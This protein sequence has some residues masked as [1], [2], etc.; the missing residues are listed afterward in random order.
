MQISDEILNKINIAYENVHK[1]K[2]L[3][4]L[5]NYELSYNFPITTIMKITDYNGEITQSYL[6]NNWGNVPCNIVKDNNIYVIQY[7]ELI[8][9]NYFVFAMPTD[10]YRAGISFVEKT[11]SYVKLKGIDFEMVLGNNGIPN[12]VEFYLKIERL[13]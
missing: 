13:Q 4:D 9:Y 2:N 11:N 3:K 7:P 8:N 6:L 1:H 12:N 5:N 10:K